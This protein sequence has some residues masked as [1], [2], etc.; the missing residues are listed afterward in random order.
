MYN[1]IAL[2]KLNVKARLNSY[3]RPACLETS[4]T[5]NVTNKLLATS[6]EMNDF[7][8]H[9]SNRLS[10][11]ELQYTAHDQCDK[12]YEKDRRRL[13]N[14]IDDGIQVCARKRYEKELCAVRIYYL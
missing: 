8:D 9:T 5:V 12:A 6:W 1:D 3:V 13:R 2:L 4:P 14:G 10:K 7:L 11:A